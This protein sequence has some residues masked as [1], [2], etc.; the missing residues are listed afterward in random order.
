MRTDGNNTKYAFGLPNTIFIYVH[1]RPEEGFSQ[2]FDDNND[3]RHES[4]TN[5]VKIIN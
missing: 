5:I 3:V 1:V 4:Q 2:K